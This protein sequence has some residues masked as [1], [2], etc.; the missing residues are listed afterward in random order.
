VPSSHFQTHTGAL[1]EHANRTQQRAEQVQEHASTVG[2]NS[3]GQGVLSELAGSTVGTINTTQQRAGTAM[4]NLAGRLTNTASTERSNASAYEQ[5]ESDNERRFTSLMEENHDPGQSGARTVSSSAGGTGGGGGGGR[6]GGG[7]PTTPSESSGGWDGPGGLHL[8]PEQNAAADTF[9]AHS[10]QSEPHISSVVQ[11]AAGQNGATL[12]GY[13]YRLKGEDSFK[14]KLA[15]HFQDNP[16]DTTQQA[17]GNMKDSVRYTMSFPSQ[18]DAYTNGVNHT[19]Q[20]FQAAGYQPVKFKN[21]WE[22]PRP[23]SGTDPGSMYQGIN[24]FWHDPSTG[25]TFEMQFHTPES[26]QAKDADT[27]A[28][29]EEQRLLPETDPR[30]AELQQQQKQIFD[31]VPR[32]NGVTGIQPLQPPRP[33]PP[34]GYL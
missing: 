12:L 19:L 25:Q 28:L 16:D 24:S 23:P 15:Q 29:Y 33:A 17:L 11:G 1:N 14:R 5:V 4:N 34:I 10:A 27:H 9:L 22:A 31:N 21:T 26:F 7:G 13:D 8:T 20:Q 2:S 3:M 18:G 6:R 30:Y 32:P